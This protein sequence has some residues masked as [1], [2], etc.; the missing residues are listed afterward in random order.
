M[1]YASRKCGTCS[2][3]YFVNGCKTNT[4]AN[5]E[6]CPPDSYKL[7]TNSLTRC[8]RCTDCAGRNNIEIQK[9]NSTHDRQCRCKHDYWYDTGALFC[10]QCSACR[11]GKGVVKECGLTADTKCQR[12]TR[13]SKSR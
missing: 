13:V 7:G 3:G 12:C 5:C 8:T 9:C 6:S 4:T 11:K 1:I 10:S 2:P